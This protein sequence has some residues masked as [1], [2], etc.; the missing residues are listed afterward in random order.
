MSFLKS[1]FE[2]IKLSKKKRLKRKNS[3]ISIKDN[4]DNLHDLL[5][6]S[7][8]LDFQKK[9]PNPLNAFGMKCFSQ[10]DEDGITI[11]ILKRIKK[12]N[13]GFFAELGVGDGTENN[14]LVLSAL[15][16]KGFW[17]GGNKLAFI[18]PRNK[19]FFFKEQ[20]ITKENILSI[21]RN[22]MEYFRIKNLD[23][24]SLDLDGNDYYLIEK[25]LQEKI[26]PKVFILEYNAKFPPPIKFKIKYD[27]HH[28]WNQDDYFGSSLETL[29]ELLS[30]NGYKLICCNSHTGANCFFINNKY[31]KLFRDIPTEIDKIYSPPRYFSSNKMMHKKSIKLIKEILT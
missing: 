14:S 2:R 29:N 5:H 9:H 16:W 18:P 22:G 27:S 8:T 21:I 4:I 1:F 25:L 3:L 24:I 31:Q 10:S 15:G 28:K 20:W 26:F 6:L 12:L 23:L 30:T 19:R 13:S 11:E 7:L 17:V